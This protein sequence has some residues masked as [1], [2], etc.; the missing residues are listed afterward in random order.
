VSWRPVRLVL[1]VVIMAALSG[2]TSAGPRAAP[3]CTNPHEGVFVLIAQSVPDATQL[4]CVAEL[5]AGWSYA[6]SQIASSVA[7]LWLDSDRAGIHA[8]EVALLPS[9][10]VTGAVKEQPAPDEVATTVYVRPET[11]EPAFTGERFLVFPGGCIRY[12][13]DF[14]PGASSALAIEA[15]EAVSLIPRSTV[16]AAVSADPG[17]TLCGAEAPPCAG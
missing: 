17:L 9:C 12:L 8:V 7:K 10:D 13:F 3:F 5:P 14:S 2:C 6:G 16:V 15:I 11:L 4:P 1:S